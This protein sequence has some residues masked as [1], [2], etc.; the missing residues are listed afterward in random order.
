MQN[1]F[2]GLRAGVTLLLLVMLALTGTAF[3]QMAEVVFSA[4]WGDLPGD[5][6]L[7]NQEEMERCGP[8][9]FT[10]DGGNLYILD[11][12]HKQ[13][14]GATPGGKSSVLAKNVT[15]WA[16]CGDGNGGVYVQTAE[17]IAHVGPDGKSGKSV[18]LKNQAGKTPK[19][20]E[21][22]GNDFDVSPQGDL[23][24]RSVKQELIPVPGAPKISSASMKDAPNASLSYRIKRL[25]KNE[26]RIIGQEEGGK[27]LVSI[28]V[29]VDGGRA[30][31][32]LFKGMDAK[33]N[34]YIEL[35][36]IKDGKIGLEVHRYSQDGKRLTVFELSN[37]YFTTV[38]KKTEIAPDGSVYQM[39]T[40]PEGVRILRYG[41][42]G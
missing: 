32:V 19:L 38:Y 39:L 12:V 7:I 27:V 15:G 16:M 2:I 10:E 11:T 42:E 5:M 8:L 33:G 40:T 18:R 4:P 24:V 34:L 26:V 37:D 9:C 35:E 1:L 17:Q 28:T 25:I 31:A 23:R 36:N 6:G 13:I 21:G 3:A 20:I 14:V 22:Y 30:G 41:K 29:Q